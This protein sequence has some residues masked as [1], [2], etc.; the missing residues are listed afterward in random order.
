[1]Q[2]LMADTATLRCQ[3]TA[4]LWLGNAMLPKNNDWYNVKNLFCQV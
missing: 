4:Q 1:M 2:I 3:T